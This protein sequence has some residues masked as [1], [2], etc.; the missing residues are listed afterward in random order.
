MGQINEHPPN[1]G[2]R[3]NALF[4]AVKKQFGI[5]VYLLPLSLLSPPPPPVPVPLPMPRL[6]R[7]NIPDSPLMTRS[8]RDASTNGNVNMSDPPPLNSLCLVQNDIQQTSRFVRVFVVGCLIP[9]IE[10]N[11]LEWS[12]SVSCMVQLGSCSLI[13]DRQFSSN[14]RLPSRLFSSTRRFFGSPSPSPSHNS[15]SSAASLP[16]TSTTLFNG[17]NAPPT[18][19]RRLAEFATVLG[20]HKLA[21]T[22]WESLRKDSKGGSVGQFS[23]IK[24]LDISKCAPPGHST[25]NRLKLPGPFA[26]CSKFAL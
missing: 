25:S 3:A 5:D 6:P 23:P 21:V 16:R 22:V 8:S 14:R 20:D 9:W 24:R 15:S 11:V 1:H 18:Q 13:V 26:S 12:E 2:C 17:P 4:N 10:K 7:P 19:Q